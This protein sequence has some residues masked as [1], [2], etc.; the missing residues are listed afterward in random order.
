MELVHSHPGGTVG[1]DVLLHQQVQNEVE[2]VGGEAEQEE[3]RAAQHH[4]QGTPLLAGC[5]P[6]IS[7]INVTVGGD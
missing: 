6:F 3:G 5:L 1:H 7:S 4:P 2:V